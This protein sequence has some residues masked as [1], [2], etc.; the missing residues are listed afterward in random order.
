MHIGLPRDKTFLDNTDMNWIFIF[1]IAL[2][3]GAPWLI[4][5]TAQRKAR[6][7]LDQG[8]PDTREVNGTDNSPRRLYY[9]HAP[10]CGPCRAMMPMI[11]DLRRDYPNLIK[12]DVTEHPELAQAFGVMGTPTFV[13]IVDSRVTEVKVGSPRATWIRNQL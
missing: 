11:D 6:Q 3:P 1:L 2:V 13:A 9:F 8:L 7:T 4:K 5:W 12:V 10:S